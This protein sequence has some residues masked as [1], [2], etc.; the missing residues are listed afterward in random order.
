MKIGLGNEMIFLSILLNIFFTNPVSVYLQCTAI[1]S[2][3]K[4]DIKM[5]D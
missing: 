2:F 4:S 5:K 1:N 3:W